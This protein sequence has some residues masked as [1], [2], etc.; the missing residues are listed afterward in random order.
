[1]YNLDGDGRNRRLAMIDKAPLPAE[2]RTAAAAYIADLT[3][4]LAQIVRRHGFNTL[5]YLLDMAKLEAE[6]VKS[7]NGPAQ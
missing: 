2:D 3:G 7:M 5:G 6:S 4:G 1:M